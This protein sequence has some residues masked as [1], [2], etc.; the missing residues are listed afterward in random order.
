MGKSPAAERPGTLRIYEQGH[1]FRNGALSFQIQSTDNDTVGVAFRLTDP[2][3]YYLWLMDSERGF[4]ALT[5]KDGAK[6]A[7]LTASRQGYVPGQWHD[8]RIDLGGPRITVYV[9]SQ[10]DLEAE[11]ARFASGTVALYAWGN[12]GVS[13]RNLMFQAK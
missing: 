6:Y 13:F 5:V 2:E 3:H 11:D 8:V 9:D 1:D 4:R 10:K 7:L 12:S